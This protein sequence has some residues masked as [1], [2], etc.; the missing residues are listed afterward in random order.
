MRTLDALKKLFVAQG[1]DE[2]V[3]KDLHTD[4]EVIDK[5]ADNKGGGG[6]L[7]T[8]TTS[9]TAPNLSYSADKTFAEIVEAANGGT[10][11]LFA[12]IKGSEKT[13]GTVV[14]VTSEVVDFFLPAAMSVSTQHYIVMSVLSLDT[15]D[16]I[17][18]ANYL[19]TAQKN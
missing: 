7:V 12:L 5:I 14:R 4:G 19:A 2:A 6:F 11:I 16:A 9:G 8:I 18:A 10:P 3:V 15:T 1:G 17:T 13:F